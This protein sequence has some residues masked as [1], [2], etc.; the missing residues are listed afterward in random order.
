MRQLGARGQVK[1]NIYQNRFLLLQELYD[2][3]QSEECFCYFRNIGL[4]SSSA[5]ARIGSMSA[6]YVVWLVCSSF[7][8]CNYQ[9]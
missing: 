7:H 2:I 5:A 6:A 4:G 1:V 3:Y 9:T 8:R